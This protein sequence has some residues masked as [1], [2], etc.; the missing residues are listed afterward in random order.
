[1][2]EHYSEI[3][4]E[5][6]LELYSSL[7]VKLAQP[8]PL[9]VFTTNYDLA[10]EKLHEFGVIELVDG[11]SNGKYLKPR[12]SRQGYDFYN[13]SGRGDVILFK[14]HGS[15]DWVRTPSEGIQRVDIPKR[16]LGGAQRVIAY[17]SQLKRDIHEEP[18]RT[19]YDYLIACLLH[20][21]VCAVIGFSF[22]D[23]EIV[24]E[25]RQAIDLNENLKLII[26]DPEAEVVRKHLENKV[27]FESI[28]L[29]SAGLR[30]TYTT[31]CEKFSH[32]TA[33]SIA[34]EIAAIVTQ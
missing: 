14:L 11:F 5:R 9:V 13:P 25:F 16:E 33:A 15:V 31:V 7:L 20:A 23:Q 21:K 18:Y 4:G 27:G 6:A 1:L 19:N 12:W 32:Q 29:D 2:V 24:E 17:P 30:P 28:T 34:H 22:R 10:I 3:D 26:I 8:H